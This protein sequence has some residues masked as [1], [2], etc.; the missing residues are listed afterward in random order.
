MLFKKIVSSKDIW[1]KR[2]KL[3]QKI[4]IIEIAIN[5]IVMYLFLGISVKRNKTSP[6]NKTGRNHNVS[7]PRKEKVNFSK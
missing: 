1:S 6:R 3:R 4:D 2:V 7:I 5:K